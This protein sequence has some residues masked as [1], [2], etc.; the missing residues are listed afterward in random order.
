MGRGSSMLMGDL[1]DPELGGYGTPGPDLLEEF[2]CRLREGETEVGARWKETGE[3]GD[4]V[5]V[6]EVPRTLVEEEEG[7]RLI[8]GVARRW[9]KALV[10]TTGPVRKGFA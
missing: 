3:E 10:V 2:L 9:G 5:L 6:V 4:E 7:A 8:E 1:V